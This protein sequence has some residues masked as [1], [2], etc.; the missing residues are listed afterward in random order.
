MSRSSVLFRIIFCVITTIPVCAFAAGSRSVGWVTI[1]GSQAF[2]S[3]Y[4]LV[5]VYGYQFTYNYTT[6]DTVDSV[7]AGL[8]GMINNSAAPVVASASA[9]VL[10]L[11][12]KMTGSSGNS[13][14]AA[15]YGGSS[16]ST[17]TV[18]MIGGRDGARNF[19][20]AM[21]SDGD[22][23][24]SDVTQT[25]FV[26]SSPSPSPSPT[27]APT[28]LPP[29]PAG[30][31]ILSIFATD[32]NLP[33]YWPSA[34]AG[35]DLT[36]VEAVNVDEP[37]LNI[38]GKAGFGT[39][40]DPCN[41]SD[42]RYNTIQNG[43][44]LLKADAAAIKKSSSKIRFWVNFSVPE[45]GWMMNGS[46]AFLN[47]S[48]ID[49]VSV[50]DYRNDF[51]STVEPMYS[52]F[53]S[54]PGYSGQQLA[55]VPGTFVFPNGSVDP[56]VQSEFLEEY[57][58]YA[59][60]ANQTC[61]LPPSSVGTTGIFDGCRVWL[62]A[63]FVFTDF[64]DCC[65]TYIGLAD[66]ATVPIQ[67]AWLAELSNPL[68]VPSSLATVLSSNQTS[69]TYFFTGGPEA[70]VI[71][72]T[73][74]GCVWDDPTGDAKAPLAALRSPLSAVW[75]PSGPLLHYL[76][77]NNNH[78]I[79]LWAGNGF[80]DTWQD[81]TSAAGALPPGPGSPLATVVA[82][83]GTAYTYYLTS[84]PEVWVIWCTSSGCVWDDPTGD[85]K[86]PLAAAGSPL[87]AVWTSS[88]PL[89][90]Y[91]TPNNG[92]LIHLWAGNGFSDTWQ[93]ETSA[94]GA[95]AVGSGSPLAT[96]LSPGGT[97]YTYYLTGGGEVW[98]IWC[99]SSA[100]IWD[101]PTGDAKAPLAAPG[102]A[103]TAVWTSNGPLVHYLT[104][105][106]HLISLWAGNGFSDTWQDE[107]VASGAVPVAAGSSLTTVLTASGAWLTHFIVPG[108]PLYSITCSTSSCS[109]A[110]ET[111]S[112]NALPAGTF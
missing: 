43:F 101:D 2:D 55:L 98:V 62:V 25:P 57:F 52:W 64:T 95:L 97:P 53:I 90:H 86:A 66:P 28:P 6:S 45:V 38:L 7:L 88:G 39:T 29:Q 81:E 105:N 35:Y 31:S 1:T 83:N 49:V 80:S 3:G 79:H 72:C 16:F 42:P 5:Q 50:D 23:T 94:S 67:A 76:I 19:P 13:P 91:L 103:L 111:R 69:F 44:A 92:H 54:H 102:S 96:V 61:N 110:D 48:Y 17:G 58:N 56:V 4:V 59:A 75:T 24:Y 40:G 77:P 22:T 63:G 33:N 109:W 84:G 26:I 9:N 106:G 18:G 73:S 99:T 21:Y 74:S 89:V 78:L 71:W 85:A 36:R 100:C 14:I 34:V 47:A 32:S 51:N 10:S 30:R 15:I 11:T 68:L 8:V 65:Q 112:A 93:D 27:P 37:Y 20:M 82:P 107:T 104:P 12:S 87:T 41:P 108:G 60:N 70:W 46:C